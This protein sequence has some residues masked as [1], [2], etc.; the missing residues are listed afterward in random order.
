MVHETGTEDYVFTWPKLITYYAE[1]RIDLSGV[2]E[3]RI[4]DHSKTDGFAKGM[5]LLQTLWFIIQCI[6][7]FSDGHLFLT[8]LELVTA[9][10]AIMSLV[11][12]ALWWNKP[13]NVDIP[14]VLPVYDTP[15]SFQSN[16]P[17][18]QD[19]ISEFKFPLS[20]DTYC[21]PSN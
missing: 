15:Q 1:G 7:R 20:F 8:E 11:M 5:A 12:Y 6:A 4:N 14:I 9:A 3:A 16:N 17:H 2:T 13:F 10:L 18:N 21:S 19:I